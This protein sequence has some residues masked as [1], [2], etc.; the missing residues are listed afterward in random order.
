MTLL[1]DVVAVS[2]QVTSTS[3]RS[4]KI[5]LLAEPRAVLDGV[6]VPIAVGLLSGV[7]RQGR[8]R[9]AGGGLRVRRRAPRETPRSGQAR[10]GVAEARAGPQVDVVVLGRGVRARE[11]DGTAPPRR[12]RPGHRRVRHG[13][14]ASRACRHEFGHDKTGD[15]DSVCTAEARPGHPGAAGSRA[16]RGS[17]VFTLSNREPRLHLRPMKPWVRRGELSLRS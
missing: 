11:A 9:P 6:E 2:E 4:A 17:S 10:Q 8:R 15:S 3:S 7:P 13:R 12:S 14:D 1:T 5:A 16:R